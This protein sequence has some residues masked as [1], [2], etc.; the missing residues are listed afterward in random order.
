MM[1]KE[2]EVKRSNDPLFVL[3][4]SAA[5]H[6]EKMVEFAVSAIRSVLQSGGQA[7]LYVPGR[8]NAFF[9]PKSGERQLMKILYCL[10]K[11]QPE[12]EKPLA[13]EDAALLQHR[14]RLIFITSEL[15]ELFL[16]KAELAVKR[17]Q[18]VMIVL[19]RDRKVLQKEKPLIQEAL[20]RGIHVE[21]L[22][23]GKTVFAGA[24]E[25]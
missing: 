4:A 22:D 10:A 16:E 23:D 8:E 7:G 6:F 15:T 11:V 13:K 17:K 14:G 21:T 24:K 18:S 19:V 1:T 5:K 2:F 20:K 3:D 9:P 12:T 25:A